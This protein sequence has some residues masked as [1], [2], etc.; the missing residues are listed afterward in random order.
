MKSAKSVKGV[1]RPLDPPSDRLGGKIRRARLKAKLSVERAAAKAGVPA[2]SWY[3]WERDY[4]M[5]RS[6][7]VAAV[8][9]ALGVSLDRLMG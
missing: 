3:A 7:K 4:Y 2:P 6:R 8:A 1:G 5:P 9:R